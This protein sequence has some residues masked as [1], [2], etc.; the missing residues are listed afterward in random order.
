MDDLIKPNEN[1][2]QS[3][4]SQLGKLRQ[5]FENIITLENE[6]TALQV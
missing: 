1:I 6:L 5:M 3:K 2:F 4:V